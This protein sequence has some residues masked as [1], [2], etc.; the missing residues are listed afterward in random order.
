MNHL[1]FLTKAKDRYGDK[2]IVNRLT[3]GYKTARLFGV[4]KKSIE[5]YPMQAWIPLTKKKSI[6]TVLSGNEGYLCPECG[7]ALGGLFGSFK[8][9]LRHGEGTCNNCKK[10]AFTLYHYVEKEQKRPLE[11]FALCGF[12]K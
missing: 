8:W 9:A 11:L 5:S 10:T 12:P 3:C 4:K 2:I 1:D 7:H 6:E